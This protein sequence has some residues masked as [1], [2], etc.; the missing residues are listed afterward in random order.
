MGNGFFHGTPK[1]PTSK[2]K[3]DTWDFIK[4]KTCVTEDPKKKMKRAH[5]EWQE[6]FTNHAPHTT[7]VTR[8]CKELLKSN[9]KKASIQKWA[10]DLS[11]HF[12]SKPPSDVSSHPL[13]MARLRG[14]T[15]K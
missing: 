3:I 5:T 10:K 8:T 9:N 2:E 6:L 4:L 13:R 7:I 1:A 14:W 12:Y 15:M 11:R